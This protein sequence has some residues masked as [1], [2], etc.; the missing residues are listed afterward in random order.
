MKINGKLFCEISPTTYKISQTKEII[1]RS[2]QNF[3][4]NEKFAKTKKEEKLPNVV[5]SHSS[6]LI[7]K[8]PGVD[9]KLQ[10]NKVVNIN[11]A[12]KSLNHIIIHPGETFSFWK[13]VG[14]T[15]KRKGYKDG[16]VIIDNKLVPGVGGGLC[17]LANT[18]HY[19]VIHSPLK[20]T[21]LHNHS[22]ALAPDEGKR[23]PYA[24]GTSVSYNNVDFRFLNNLDQ[25]VQIVVW[26]DEEK[27]YA[28]LRSE[29]ELPHTY[30]IVEEDHHFAKENDKYFR[31]SKIYKE[32]IDK[33]SGK[34]IKKELIR[35]NHSEVMYD[36]SLIPEELIK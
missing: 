27:S 16:R 3:F 24:N 33:D 4:S 19:I 17:N 7:K 1:K 28:Q 31:I 6:A 14:N 30:R 13:I 8:G 22:D 20:V 11:I 36:Y 25:D 10:Q 23:V 18:I 5:S 21:E 35:D 26:C 29:R 15:T 12:N 32:T 9:L 34:V 2:I